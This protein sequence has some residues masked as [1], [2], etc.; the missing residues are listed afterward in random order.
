MYKEGE[1]AEVECQMMLPHSLGDDVSFDDT[2]H[3]RRGRHPVSILNLTKKKKE[4]EKNKCSLM[5]LKYRS[6]T[7]PSQKSALTVGMS[8]Q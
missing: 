8:Q 3:R 6:S 4:E 2:R 7:P 1:V 5:S